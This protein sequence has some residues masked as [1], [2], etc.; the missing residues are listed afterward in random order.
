MRGVEQ[1]HN[2]KPTPIIH[3]DI[4][5]EN[6]MLDA[7]HTVAKVCDFGLAK[8][9]AAG[10][11]GGSPAGTPGWKAPETYCQEFT[12]ASDVFSLA[13]VAFH[14]ATLR[15]PFAGLDQTFIENML[16]EVE[17]RPAETQ[18]QAK[19][20]RWEKRMAKKYPEHAG[21][22]PSIAGVGLHS[23]RGLV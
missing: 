22:R 12:P 20:E 1:L 8:T 19:I 7:S 9:A 21:R 15:L 2:L 4:K 5:R 10:R 13:M 14:C 3:R 6:V 17:R 23:M 11:G 16:R 18:P